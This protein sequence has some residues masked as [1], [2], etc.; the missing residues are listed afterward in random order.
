VTSTLAKFFDDVAAGIGLG[1]AVDRATVEGLRD[2]LTSVLDE[3]GGHLP[4]D[5]PMLVLTKSRIRA[6]L[7][8]ETGALAAN[9]VLSEVT[10]PM[11][12]GRLVDRVASAYVLAGAV[13]N[14]PFDHAVDA[15]RAERDERAVAWLD[16][17]EA[18][19]IRELRS[20]L[21]DR[22]A[23]VEASWPAVPTEWWPRLED[24]ARIPFA[25]G[26][27]VLSGRFDLTLG[28]RATPLERVIVEIKAGAATAVHQPDLYWYGLLSALRD[29]IPPRVV[30]VWSA[31]DGIT[32]T[33]P[34]TADALH[35]AAMRVVAAAE[36]WVELLSGREPTLT[37]HPGC[38]W[39]A[40]LDVCE[41]GQRW[42]PDGDA[43]DDWLDDERD[44]ANGEDA[45]D[46]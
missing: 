6:V 16:A 25:G 11:M 46:A 8:C 23:R 45:T 13:P 39:C 37:A 27:R 21:A 19:V 18:D 7:A 12:L 41:T 2:E 14:D 3:I 30:A 36:R 10:A 24:A 1:P 20:D 34:V 29:R 40:L 31:A 22:A 5:A 33:A 4:G 35:S 42:S 15:L 43:D 28:G 44:A 32:T 9:E 17:A 38:R 26:R